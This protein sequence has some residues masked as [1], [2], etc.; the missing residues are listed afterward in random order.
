MSKDRF[1][2]IGNYEPDRQESMQRFSQMLQDGLL[3]AGYVVELWKP[4]VWLGKWSKSTLQGLGKWLGYIDKWILFPLQ[5]RWR[6]QKY[7][8]RK[9]YFHICDHS[10]APYLPHLPHY[11][12]GITCHDILAIRGALGHADA[13]CPA[14]KTGKIF[15]NWIGG[16]L[17]KASILAADSKQTLVHLEEYIG[18]AITTADRWRVIHVGFNGNFYPLS[19]READQLLT[20]NV[21]DLTKPYLLHVGS[22]LPRKNRNMLVETLALLTNEWRGVVC[23]AGQPVDQPLA[24]RIKELGIEDRIITVV[25]PSHQLLL[26]LYRNCEAF[27]FPSFSEG[28]GWPVIEA[29]ACGVPVISSS[30]QPIPEVSGDGALLADPHQ[31]VSFADAFRQLHQPGKREELIQLGYQNCER[32]KVADM[33]DAYL[34]LYGLTRLT[35]AVCS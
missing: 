24:D 2:L 26:A 5:L 33:I 9:V 13:Y 19:T 10:N 25:K 31:P 22:S 23:F 28:F 16:H 29:Q 35:P 30:I 17:K 20:T 11:Q 3:E 21:P 15:Q 8:K 7:K 4:T 18:K 1:I 34:N 32:F 6:V 27:V 12:T 14:S